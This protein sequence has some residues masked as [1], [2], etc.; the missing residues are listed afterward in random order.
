MPLGSLEN[1]VEGENNTSSPN[2]SRPGERPSWHFSQLPRN[3]Q[4]FSLR[5]YSYKILA[6]IN[7]CKKMTILS[8]IFI[9]WQMDM[10]VGVGVP[11]LSSPR[12]PYNS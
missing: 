1:T 11:Q 3:L 12:V 10:L 6:H 2:P 9:M 7:C 5:N 4:H 8:L